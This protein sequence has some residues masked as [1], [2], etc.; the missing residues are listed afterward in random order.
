[1]E[2]KWIN[3]EQLATLYSINKPTQEKLRSKKQIP[4]SRI[5]NHI[6]YH[7]DKIDDWIERHSI[8]DGSKGIT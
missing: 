1:M 6:F 8:T 2:T 4:Y 7:I 5:G 3:Q